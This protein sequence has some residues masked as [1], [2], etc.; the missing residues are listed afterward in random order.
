MFSFHLASFPTTYSSI[1]PTLIQFFCQKNSSTFWYV[2]FQISCF[3]FYFQ[4]TFILWLQF[5][6]VAYFKLLGEHQLFSTSLCFN[7][8]LIPFLSPYILTSALSCFL[9]HHSLG[10]HLNLG[11]F[12]SFSLLISLLRLPFFLSLHS[13]YLSFYS[14]FFFCLPL[15][16][17]S[18]L[19]FTFP[20]NPTQFPFFCFPLHWLSPYYLSSYLVFVS[21]HLFFSSFFPYSLSFP[22]YLSD[23]FQPYVIFFC[24]Q[25]HLIV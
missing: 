6:S 21:F 20:P 2:S 25:M 10:F 3:C 17:L 1:P 15:Q 22:V 11:G 5:S 4:S 18:A 23:V 12:Q 16:W 14:I 7:F 13:L 19:L 8:L 24:Y 9:Y